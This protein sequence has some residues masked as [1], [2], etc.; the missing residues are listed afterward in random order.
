MNGRLVELDEFL[1]SAIEFAGAG[2]RVRP[3]LYREVISGKRDD[4][5]HKAVSYTHL[6]AHETLR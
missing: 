6:R 1:T 4:R 3:G 2:D 5:D